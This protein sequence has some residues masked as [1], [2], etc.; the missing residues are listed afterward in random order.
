MSSTMKIGKHERHMSDLDF[1]R[2]IFDEAVESLNDTY[3]YKVV[4]DKVESNRKLT[5]TRITRDINSVFSYQKRL[6]NLN[7]NKQ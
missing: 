5:L 7:K 3:I 4:Q 2:D 6:Y 1:M